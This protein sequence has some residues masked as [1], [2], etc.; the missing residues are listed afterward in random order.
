MATIWPYKRLECL[1]IP[2]LN[3][4]TQTKVEPDGDNK[5]IA[6]IVHRVFLDAALF[7]TPV[8][9]V[10]LIAANMMIPYVKT[11]TFKEFAVSFRKFL[12]EAVIK[13]TQPLGKEVFFP[14]KSGNWKGALQQWLVIHI[15]LCVPSIIYL[16][17]FILLPDLY[18]KWFIWFG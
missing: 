17:P 16:L 1:E 9:I 2:K 3:F 8:A 18:Y 14:W 12:T 7:L 6:N 11:F 5:V 10:T 15:Y 4:N 13:P